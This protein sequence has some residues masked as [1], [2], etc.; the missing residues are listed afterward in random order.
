[1][2]EFKWHVPGPP[3]AEVTLRLH[4]GSGWLARKTLTCDGRVVFERGHFTGAET[5]FAARPDGAELHLRMVPIAHSTDWRPALFA[6]DM[7]IP[8]TT[9]SAPPR[10][11]PPPKTLA[12]PVGLTYLLMAIVTAMLPQTSAILDAAYLQYDDRKAVL[13][14][15]DP[16]EGDQALAVDTADIAPA[17]IGQQ[18]MATLRAMGGTP[19]YRWAQATSGWPRGWHL[20]PATG[21]LAG[22]PNDAHDLMFRV[23][24]TDDAQTKVEW[25]VALVVEPAAARTSAAPAI[26]TRTLP[27]ATLGHVY[28]AALAHSGGQPPLAW[29]TLGKRKLPEGVKINENTGV[30]RGTP[31]KAGLFPVTIR[32]ED[33]AYSSARDIQHWIVPFLT[34]AVCLLGFLAMRRWS[35]WAFGALIGLQAAALAPGAL[36]ATTAV[37]GQHVAE[38][39]AA[40]LPVA[41]T[42][43]GLQALLWLV[44]LAHVGKMR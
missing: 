2:Y 4:N 26:T 34:T 16:N 12:I 17:K 6:G 7:E 33:S 24:V 18:Y 38:G 11:V 39:I 36:A 13:R 20:D 15:L 32:V 14:V 22:T 9:R 31:K 25:P 3:S 8:E 43:L 29:K 1:M 44:G 28:E 41:H 40:L 21:L 42:A 5:R 19:P 23:M 10:I 37:L 30:V 27:P 35:V